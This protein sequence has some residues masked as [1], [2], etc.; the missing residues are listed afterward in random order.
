MPC[1]WPGVSL[2]RRDFIAGVG[3]ALAMPVVAR[4]QQA[5]LPVVGFLSSLTQPDSS[6]L[7]AAFRRGL[8]ENG[9]VEGQS[10][11]VDY[12]WAD[13]RYDRLP[14]L[15]RDLVARKVSVLVSTGGQP[16][17]LAAKAAASSTPVVFATGVDPVQSGI[18][19][20]FNRPGGNLTGVYIVTT[21]LEA[22]RFGLLQE[23]IPASAAIAVLI[24]PDNPN[25]SSQVR[26]VQDAARAAGRPV[27]MVHARAE[28]ELDTAF[29][30]IGQIKPAALMIASD[31]WLSIQRDRLVELARRSRIPTMYQWREFAEAGGLMSYGTNLADAYRQVGNYVG[32][33]LK[34][35]KPAEIPVAQP[36]KFELVI[37]LK[38]SK[39]LNL[40][41]PPGVL[42]IADE[43]IE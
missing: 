21:G 10:I 30:T 5:V 43:V 33:I 23:L 17:L 22:K 8:R 3:G 11:A 36:T 39:A 24:N 16:T 25:M 2:K 18:V 35:A 34:G 40:Q 19:G 12:R 31:P 27:H 13:G 38:T 37:N 41:I 9:F 15:A 42:A 20:S 32:Q 28:P 4:A 26:D 6:H 14:G 1:S 29:A 7:I